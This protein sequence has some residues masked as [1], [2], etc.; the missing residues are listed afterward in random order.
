M[1]KREN[2]AERKVTSLP[3]RSADELASH[4]SWLV[5]GRSG[6]GKT[7]FAGSFPGPILFLDVADKG[8]DSIAGLK[9]CKIM[10]LKV[11]DDFEMVYW[12][13]KDHEGEYATVVVDTVTQLQQFAIQRVLDNKGK[14]SE[15]AGDWGT[16]TKKEWG[17]VASMM[18]SWITNFRDL[19]MEVIFIAQDRTFNADEESMSQTDVLMPEV[20]PRLSPSVATHLNA[21]VSVIGNTYIREKIIKKEVKK[22]GFKKP[23]QEEKSVY[24]YCMRVGPNPI[25]ITKLRK[26]RNIEPPSFVVDPTYSDIVDIIKGE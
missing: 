17:D 16:M 18:K 5:Y 24:Q 19:P 15:R 7:T 21:S 12:Y 3:V 20:G 25:Y 14:D 6:S 10:E 2:P 22:S 13:L 11:W 1:V 9:D 8:T 23:K 26:P 4:R